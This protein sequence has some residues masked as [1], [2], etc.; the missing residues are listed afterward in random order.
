MNADWDARAARTLIDLILPSTPTWF[1]DTS[2]AERP[3]TQGIQY[4]RY[5]QRALS[6]DIAAEN[7]RDQTVICDIQQWI[8]EPSGDSA[9]INGICSST[10]YSN[11]WEDLAYRFFSDNRERILLLCEKALERIRTQHGAGASSDSQGFIAIWRYS[12]R[13]VGHVEENAQWLEDRITEAASV[14]LELVNSLWHYWGAGNNSILR[15]EDRDRVRR[16]IIEVLR[17]EL[18]VELLARITH[19]TFRYVIY[20]LVFDPGSHSPV[21]AGPEAWEWMGSVLL[22][23]LQIGQLSTAIGVCSLI[24]AREGGSRREPS[25][26]DLALLRAFFGGDAVEAVD[27]IERLIP[28]VD[29]HERNLVA[30]IV[31]S[32][33]AGLLEEGKNDESE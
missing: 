33:R 7:V 22:G 6:E 23:G 1:D 28:Q 15:P 25:S 14:S 3:R 27:A 31:Q 18:T 19:P 12:N 30:D 16:H 5:W 24:A 17:R 4:E 11:V 26:A 21:Q 10:Y 9:L 8:D 13:H 2:Y 32:A 20:Q 29:E